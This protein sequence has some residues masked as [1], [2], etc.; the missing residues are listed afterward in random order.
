VNGVEAAP[1][2][3]TP[4]VV[5]DDREALTGARTHYCPGC[6][7]GIVHRLVAAALDELGIRERTV[8]IAAI[9]CAVLIYDYLDID[10]QELPHGRAPA[11]ASALKR[12]RPDLVVFTYQGDGDL[13][14]I[15]TAE[16]VH[17]A[18]RSEHIT[19]I[20]VNN[21]IYGMTGGQMAPTSLVGQRTETTP[22]GRN[23]ALQ[24]YPIRVSEM[25]ATL[26]GAVYIERVSV[27]HPE[28]VK[29]AYRAV[30]KAFTY[31]LEG[32]GF[33]MVEVLSP[34]PT[35]WGMKPVDAMRWIDDTMSRYFPLGVIKD[36]EPVRF[37]HLVEHPPADY[38]GGLM[39]GFHYETP[40]HA[41]DAEPGG[42]EQPRPFGRPGG[43]WTSVSVEGEGASVSA[44]G[45]DAEGEEG[46]DG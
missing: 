12:V 32:R 33:S 18:A 15:G 36:Q 41:L 8:G 45:E 26:D 3:V 30:K 21:G 25:L 10:F 42:P 5:L 28:N 1:S 23:A 17:A 40:G 2:L 20:F 31:Q 43:R 37:A 34:C 19:V 27:T 29:C 6:G 39:H 44:E 4:P 38:R 24:G 22:E 11:G 46:D 14:A 9:G 35:N 7:H 16:I 13:A